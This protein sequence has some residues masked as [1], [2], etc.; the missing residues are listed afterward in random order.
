[1]DQQA[2]LRTIQR[3]GK[4]TR[5][6]SAASVSDRADFNAWRKQPKN[7]KRTNKLFEYERDAG[8]PA[9]GSLVG[10]S[11]H[12]ERPLIMFNYTST[13]HNLL[14]RFPA[15]WTPELRRCRGIVF[16]RQG[17]LV[18]LPFPKFFNAGEVPETTDLPDEPFIA[19]AKHDGHLGIIFNHEGDWLLTTRGEF[20]SP[21][22][23]IG[24]RMLAK[25][26]RRK[27][28]RELGRNVN[29]LVEIIHPR[30]RV[31]LD[32]RGWEGFILIGATNRS[33]LEDYRHHVVT[34]LAG[35][36]GLKQAEMWEG[37]NIAELKRLVTDRSVTDKEGYVV[38]FQNG[39][40]VKFKYAG[41][42]GLMVASK[43]SYKYLMNRIAAGNLKKMIDTL[44][45]EVRGEADRM[46]GQLMAVKKI[47]DVKARRTY[48][49]GLVPPDGSTAYYRQVC[50]NFLKKLGLDE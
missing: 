34:D 12:P 43:L 49:Y 13:A 9:I 38:R 23:K 17:Q 27:G 47:A 4:F 35:Q 48:L 39:L 29:P 18:A 19:T 11:F 36:L 42:I 21:T 2:L 45:E 5:L 50:R 28:W 32:Y 10:A 20:T 33:S 24:N 37:R 14:H 46:V 15:G 44:D 1:M 22:A 40:R 16:D 7:E 30:T 41:Y 31:H 26:L 6:I 3:L 8:M 25:C